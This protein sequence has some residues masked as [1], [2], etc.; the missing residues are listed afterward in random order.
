MRELGGKVAVV[1]GAASGIG[2]GI[3]EAFASEG[4]R[5]MLA[6]LDEARLAA[7]VYRM[8]AQ[9]TEVTGIKVDV[10]D[11]AQVRHLADTAVEVFGGVDVICNNAGTIRP[12]LTWELP[13]EDWDLVLRVNL[14]GVINGVHTF[15]PL[16]L[17]SG[18]EGHVVNVGS[19]ASVSPTLGIGPYNVSK[20]GVLVLSEVLEAELRAEGA[21]IGVSVI[22]PGRVKSRLGRPPG[23][24]DNESGLPEPGLMQPREVGDKVVAAIR[25]NRLFVFTHPERVAE[26]RE[27]FARITEG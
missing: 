21:P 13:M 26:V 1:T 22:M 9:G 14:M 3:A 20:H 27:R 5:L 12:G 25:E 16:M 10:G 23:A 11:L 8:S 4:M 6:D 17:A 7:E 18:R 15:V 24:P 19:M 2:L